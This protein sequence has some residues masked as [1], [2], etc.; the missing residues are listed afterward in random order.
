MKTVLLKETP[1]EI[2]SGRKP[3]ELRFHVE[4]PFVR[5]IAIPSPDKRRKEWLYFEAMP[6]LANYIGRALPD[7]VNPRSHEDDCLKS[8]VAREIEKTILE[9]PE[10]MLL[11][12]RG[13]T[14]VADSFEFDAKRGEALITLTDPENHGIADGGTTDAVIAKVQSQLAAGKRWAELSQAERE[15]LLGECRVPLH[16][17]VGVEDRDRIGNLVKGR[18]TSRQVRP[19]SLADF[20]G[21]FDWIK[22][23]LEAENSPVR[24]RVGYEENATKD[25]S[26][27]DVLALVTLFHPIWDTEDDEGLKAPTVAYASKGRLDKIMVKEEFAAGYR[28]LSPVILDILD[29]HDHVYANFGTHYTRAAGAKG[30][31]LGRRRGIEV[32]EKAMQLPFSTRTS[33]YVISNG[34]IYPL[35][36]AFRACLKFKRGSGEAAWKTSPINFYTDHGHKLVKELVNQ[37]DEWGSFNTASKKRPVYIAVHQRAQLLLNKSDE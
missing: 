16:I 31:R 17:I 19:W 25:V 35:L 26:I 34:Y 9:N 33:E 18:N 14:I 20:S 22:D 15:Q 29:L 36:A 28:N 12:S 10:D 24:G 23:I 21:D 6:S 27:L 11:A 2:F 8:S 1:P 5:R 30:A 7:G 32:A 3:V 4:S 37:I 13:I